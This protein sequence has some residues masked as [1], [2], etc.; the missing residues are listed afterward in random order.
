M[1]VILGCKNKE[2]LPD[3][4]CHASTWQPCTRY[5]GKAWFKKRSCS[6]YGNSTSDRSSEIWPWQQIQCQG[7]TSNSFLVFLVINAC[8][9]DKTLLYWSL[10]TVFPWLWQKALSAAETQGQVISIQ[11]H[12][13]PQLLYW[14]KEHNAAHNHLCLFLQPPPTLRCI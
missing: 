11:Y 10:I 3:C 2:G 6:G 4:C 7:S 13:K 5:G 14:F 1:P 8:L 12:R 9:K